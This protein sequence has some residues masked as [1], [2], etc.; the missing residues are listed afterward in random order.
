M[1]TKIIQRFM[2]PEGYEELVE[3]YNDAKLAGGSR[4]YEPTEEEVTAFFAYSD[5]ELS[6]EEAAELFGVS[7]QTVL[8]RFGLIGIHLVRDG[9][10]KAP[11]TSKKRKKRKA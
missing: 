7:L 10:M 4:Y 8:S 3:K 1:S 5:G 9:K 2:T 6:K 11:Q